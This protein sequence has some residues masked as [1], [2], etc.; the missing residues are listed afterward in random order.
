MNERRL[1]AFILVAD[2]GSFSKA[3]ALSYIST[4]AMVRQIN[5]LEESTGLQLFDR[6]PQGVSL[7]RA[8]ERFYQSAKQ[9]LAIYEDTLDIC[10]LEQEKSILTIA[11]D[12]NLESVTFRRLC[13]DYCCRHPEVQIRFT[14][15]MPEN[16]NEELSNDNWQMMVGMD[17]HADSYE[18]CEFMPIHDEEDDFCLVLAC[19]AEEAGSWSIRDPEIADL[20]RG[21]FAKIR[22]KDLDKVIH[23]SSI[24]DLDIRVSGR[25]NNFDRYEFYNDLLEG[26]AVIMPSTFAETFHDVRVIHTGIPAGTY[27]ILTKKKPSKEVKR[28]M[29]EIFGKMD[30]KS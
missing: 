30:G 7:T 4:P 8:G 1:K 26:R 24:I 23:D 28:F 6:T 10:K 17:L 20:I 18:D 5:M 11:Y 15:C 16:I 22:D 29:V 13:Y 3:A 21:I 2:C 12:V 14:N 27:G 19:K 9:I 25:E